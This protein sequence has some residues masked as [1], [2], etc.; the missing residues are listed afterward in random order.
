LHA[1]YA[2]G[3]A[4][5]A[6]RHWWWRSRQALVLNRLATLPDW[7][8]TRVPRIL[9]VGCGSGVVLDALAQLG[10]AEGLEPD[11]TLARSATGRS[12]IH[13][14]HFGPEYRP[15]RPYDLVVMLDVLEHLD[16]DL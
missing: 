5:L 10:E 8:G 16:D 4:D 7:P 13:R 1:D 15:E 6:R 2:E 14:G 3:Y 9:D 12:K 11:E